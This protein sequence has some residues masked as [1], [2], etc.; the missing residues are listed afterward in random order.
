M[1][2][3]LFVGI[4]S[5]GLSVIV[6]ATPLFNV[7]LESV[8]RQL[9]PQLQ[10]LGVTICYKIEGQLM[11]CKKPTEKVLMWILLYADD[12]SLACDTAEKLRVAVTTMD[13][14]FLRRGLTISTKKTKV[15]VVGRNAAAQAADS[16]IML[17]GD[18]LEVFSQFKYLGS[19]FNS[20]CTLDAEITHRGT[21]A[22]SAFQ[23]L[24]RVN[25]WSSRALTLFVKMQFFQC[26]VMSVLLY[27]G[28][29]WAVVKQHISPLAVFQMNC[30]RRICGISLRDHVPNVDILNR[31]H[32]LSVESQ[33]QSKR[34]R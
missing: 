18:Q 13:A 10:Q 31:C 3:G 5:A 4:K 12:I 28:E 17:R 19:V 14:T 25:I 9:L 30:L 16:V 23:Q 32:T 11:H 29:T 24:R 1:R 6:L 20:D 2:L 8:I 22:N 34:L 21:A 26:I 33:L 15:L 7:C 27:S